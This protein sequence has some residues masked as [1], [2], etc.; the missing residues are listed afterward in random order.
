VGIAVVVELVVG[1]FL[2][3]TARRGSRPDWRGARD[4]IVRA[5]SGARLTV[6][7][8]SGRD[9]LVYYLRP[10][11][12]RDGGDDPHPGIAVERLALD[13]PELAVRVATAAE[14]RSALFVVLL[15]D[16]LD[17]IERDADAAAILTG[18]QLGAGDPRDGF[19]LL[20]V[21][22]CAGTRRDETVY[23]FRAR[24]ER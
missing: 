4:Q 1:T 9:S 20:D 3:T 15:Q 23:V 17:A 5:V 10:D 18:G 11:H 24:G 8:A 7:A 13:A 12:W 6:L 21:L 22:P 19:E 2:Y 16:E 14:R